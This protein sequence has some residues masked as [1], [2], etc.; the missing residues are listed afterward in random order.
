MLFSKR[1]KLQSFIHQDY[2]GHRKSYVLFE[3]TATYY[4]LAKFKS[5]LVNRST[6]DVTEVEFGPR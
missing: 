1:G 4:H 2:V 5:A 3:V 6:Q